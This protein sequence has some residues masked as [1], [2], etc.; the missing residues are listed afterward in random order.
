MNNKEMKRTKTIGIK[1]KGVVKDKEGKVTE[2]IEKETDLTT[3]NFPRWIFCNTNFGG[4]KMI[5]TNGVWYTVTL[6]N[7]SGKLIIDI[8]SG[9]TTPTRDDLD[10]KSVIRR[11][12]IISADIEYDKDQTDVLTMSAN[13]YNDTAASW[14]VKEV[15]L[16]ARYIADGAERAF[17]LARDLFTAT[18]PPGGSLLIAYEITMAI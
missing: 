1:V 11:E 13:F 10:L 2:E 12:Y 4:I 6:G 18:V 15:G 9:E 5:A 3:R 17:L 16:E 14:Y 7:M 8:G